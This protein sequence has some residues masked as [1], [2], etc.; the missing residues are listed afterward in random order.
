MSEEN[1]L[2][3][4]FLYLVE[5]VLI[6]HLGEECVSSKFL[7][8]NHPLLENLSQLHLF[9]KVLHVRKKDDR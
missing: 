4:P 1:T 3:K 2:W 8:F 7:V 9:T 5:Q 6:V